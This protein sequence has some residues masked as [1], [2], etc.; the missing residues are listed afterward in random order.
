M[1]FCALR[2]LA[3]IAFAMAATPATVKIE[4]NDPLIYYHGR[5]DDSPGTWW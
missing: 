3:L 1:L 2:L 4:N 5:W